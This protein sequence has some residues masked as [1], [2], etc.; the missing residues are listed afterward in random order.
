M[1][2]VSHAAITTRRL[3]PD[4]AAGRINTRTER[5]LQLD[6]GRL[7]EGRNALALIS[8]PQFIINELEKVQ[9][10]SNGGHS[11]PEHAGGVF[12]DYAR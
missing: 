1:F 10:F 11:P 7:L 6:K 12:I 9:A 8:H 4:E 3:I 5:I 2:S